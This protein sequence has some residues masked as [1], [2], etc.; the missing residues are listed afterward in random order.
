LHARAAEALELLYPSRLAEYADRLALH[1]FKGEVWEKAAQYALQAGNR[2]AER[3]GVREAARYGEQGLDALAQVPSTTSTLELALHLRHLVYHR[4]FALGA[5]DHVVAWAKESAA[6]AE[7]LGDK[8][9]LAGAK[10]LFANALWFTCENQQA[11]AL[12]EL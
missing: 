11:L 9:S 6:I 8:P 7:K 12:A 2:A 1:T 5:R 4:Y 3:S 10:N